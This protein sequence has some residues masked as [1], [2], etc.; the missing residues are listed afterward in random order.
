MPASALQHAGE[1]LDLPI[2]GMTCAACASRIEK[3]LKKVNGVSNA[4]VNLATERATIHYDPAVTGPENLVGTIRDTGYDAI[5]PT[6]HDK[7]SAAE[8]HDH[9]HDEAYSVTRRKFIIAAV[10][11]LPVLVIAM[12]HGRV[13]ALDFTGVRWVQL[14]LTTP[15]VFYSGAQ[16][17][18]GAW[19]ALRHRAADM[20]TLIAMGTGAAYM[21]SVAVVLFP[22]FFVGQPSVHGSA[23]S[24][25]PPVYFEAAAVIIALVL[26]GRM[27]ESRARGNTSEAIRRLIGLQAKTAKVARDG[28]EVETPIADVRIGDV[29]VVRPGER[30]PL[31]G[32]IGEG[33]SSIDESML[34]GE[35]VP[36]DKL[37]GDTVYGGTVNLTGAFRFEVTKVGS[38]TVLAR[39]VEMVEQAQG[40]KAP[41]ARLA[42]VVSGIFT[43]IVLAI[44]I[45]TFAIWFAVSPT[46]V[47]LS[48]ALAN[49]VSVLIIACP[50]ALGLA[51]PTAIMVATGKAAEK[52]ILVKT[53][54]S[55]ERAHQMTTIVL[56]KTGTV[57]TGLPILTDIISGNGMSD[58]ELL[59]LVAS[60]ESLSEHPIARAIVR[61]A[62]EKKFTISKA[63]SFTALP[64]HGVDATIDERHVL[65]G[66]AALLAARGIATS[67]FSSQAAEFSSSGKT[68][69]FAAIDGTLA[70]VIAVAD[71]PRADSAAAVAE[72]RRLGL[73]VVMV[74]GDNRRTAE[75]VAKQVGI[76]HV[77]AEVL[78]ADKAAIVR[79]LQSEGEV[80]GMVG[81]GINDAP[82]LAQA[83]VGIAVGTGTDIAIEAADM[84]LLRGDL[85][86]VVTA[87]ALSNATIRNVKQNLFW[88]FVYNVIGI[89]IAAGALYPVTGWLL[90]PI[91]ASAAMSLSSVSVVSNSLRLRNFGRV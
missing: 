31:D 21:Y 91:L 39:I 72:L 90:S 61:V 17:Y 57:T 65:L 22:G 71:Q 8:A 77:E 80:V 1:R 38:D 59:T 54:A 48:M 14:L 62:E 20:N 44:A 56:D 69:I 23:G 52:G 36:V 89:P 51:T 19:A 34:T 41:I 18:R 3:S 35:S 76:N 13:P 6:P 30:I 10:L 58:S 2:T 49:F 24:M 60:V 73:R 37:T 66:N 33:N 26:L 75:A 40:S 46:E 84:T 74:T 63:T 45:V 5:L 11:A 79:R 12:S 15:V 28:R 87:I 47:R 43:P 32:T 82:A 42:D 81:D 55:L 64:G 27:L 68:V 83:D 70:G 67:A 7:M 16:F 50:C 9:A 86:R 29:V 4:T 85:R 25:M 78:P 53:G 88:A